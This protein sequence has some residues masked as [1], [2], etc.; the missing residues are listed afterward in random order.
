MS[1]TPNWATPWDK[2]EDLWKTRFFNADAC[3]DKFNAKVRPHHPRC[4]DKRAQP[5]SYC[6]LCDRFI[7]RYY[8]EETN[9]L[10]QEYGEGGVV[11]CNPPYH[12]TGPSRLSLWVKTAHETSYNGARWL[13][14]LPP[15]IDT[16]WYHDY[17]WDSRLKRPREGVDLDFVR[18]RWHFIDPTPKKRKG[19][20]QGTMLVEFFPR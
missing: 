18:G 11:F 3:A 9:G 12:S 13:L 15:G 10:A 4:P 16:G 1:D 5:G 2:F 20:R 19:G 17:I 8:T 7:G 14:V 6:L